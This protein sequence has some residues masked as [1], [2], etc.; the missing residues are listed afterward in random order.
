MTVDATAVAAAVTGPAFLVAG[1]FARAFAGFVR[2]APDA[3]LERVA[4]PF[5]VLFAIDPPL[6]SHSTRVVAGLALG[7]DDENAIAA[8][9][10]DERQLAR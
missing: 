1:F 10:S 6:I 4:P 5:V 3:F 7:S 2:L 9:P 8:A